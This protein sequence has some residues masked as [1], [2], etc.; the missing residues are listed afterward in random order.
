MSQPVCFLLAFSISVI[1]HFAAM[2]G[3]RAYQVTD[4]AEVYTAGEYVAARLVTCVAAFLAA[5]LFALISRYDGYKCALLLC[6]RPP[7]SSRRSATCI[8]AYSKSMAGLTLPG[9]RTCSSPR[10]S[11]SVSLRHGLDG[12]PTACLRYIYRFGS[13]R[14]FF[15]LKSGGSAGSAG[16]A[17]IL[18]E[19]PF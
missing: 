18:P 12:L 17:F 2:Y 15:S 14:V 13:W 3:V 4:V 16:R 5:F 6:C 19:D 8:T 1:F 10:R 7:R 11:L 9:R